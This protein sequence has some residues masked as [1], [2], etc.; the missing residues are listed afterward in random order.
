VGRG[1]LVRS[2]LPGASVS[3]FRLSSFPSSRATRSRP[4]TCVRSS[5]RSMTALASICVSTTGS[6]RFHLSATTTRPGLARFASPTR[7][8]QNGRR[9]GLSCSSGLADHALDGSR[10][11]VRRDGRTA[12]R[13]V[14]VLPPATASCRVRGARARSQALE[15]Q[16]GNGGLPTPPQTRVARGTASTGTSH[17]PALLWTPANR[18]ARL[19][20]AGALSRAPGSLPIAL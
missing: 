13:R 4:S 2:F 11:T 1:G 10:H 12:G 3:S 20:R 6:R 15:W 19:A 17:A 18:R 8:P 9:P 16:C 14:R 7:N 5:T